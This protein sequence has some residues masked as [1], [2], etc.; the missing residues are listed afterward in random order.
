M[1]EIPA[2][3]KKIQNQIKPSSHF[4][5]SFCVLHCVNIK[6]IRAVT[7][8]RNLEN[9]KYHNHQVREPRD[10]LK[11]FIQKKKQNKA[12]THDS[13][14]DQIRTAFTHFNKELPASMTQQFMKA[15]LN[16]KRRSFELGKEFLKINYIISVA[17]K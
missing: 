8:L 14:A 10:V 11:I 16:F 12:V 15:N 17:C 7:S 3:N 6:I 2:T 1:S 13:S 5:S 9:K 4:F